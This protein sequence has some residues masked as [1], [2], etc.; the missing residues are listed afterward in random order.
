M[1]WLFMRPR[2]QGLRP[3]PPAVAAPTYAEINAEP[4][5]TVTALDPASGDAPSVIGQATPLR[6]KLPPGQYK[7]TLQGPNREAK[8]VEVTVPASGGA[9]CFAVFKKPDLNRI[10]GRE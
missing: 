1:V 8:Q 9:S 2:Q 5:A 10:V 4:W 3:P 6:V 7:V